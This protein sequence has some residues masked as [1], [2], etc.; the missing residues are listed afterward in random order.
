MADE[1]EKGPEGP[2][3]HAPGKPLERSSTGATC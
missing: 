3:R 1:D 2:P